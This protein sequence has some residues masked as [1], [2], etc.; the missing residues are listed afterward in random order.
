[1]ALRLE[2]FETDLP[3]AA[4]VIVTDAATLEE[5]RL[6]SYEEGYSAGWEDA[7]TAQAEDQARMRSDL[8]RT[9]QA[10]GFTYHEA[11]MHVLRA[12]EPLLAAVISRILPD[13]AREALAPIVLETLM[14]LAEQMAEAPVTLML[15][16]ASRPAVEA[17]LEEATG[18]PL[19]LV[20]EPTLGE[21]QVSLRL[22]AAET[23][24]DLDRAVAEIAL[25]VRNFFDLSE[26]EIRHG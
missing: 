3:E 13:V 14:P 17:L 23:Q 21:G 5:G 15:N 11:R 16:P 25:A 26:Q 7:T 1:M 9:M 18:L 8:A 2:V 19:T 10:L 24:V 12:V 22:G 20:D 6:A 4:E